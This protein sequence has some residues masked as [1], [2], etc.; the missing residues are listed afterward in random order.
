MSTTWFVIIPALGPP[1]AIEVF[2]TAYL[3][4]GIRGPDA[5]DEDEALGQPVEGK[6]SRFLIGSS[7]INPTHA[8]ALTTGHVP[9]IEKFTEFPPP[10]A[11][12]PQERP[13]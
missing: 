13:E 5:P 12:E 2:R 3:A 8:A 4:Q 11:W 1:S 10:S 7:R 9:W 6:N